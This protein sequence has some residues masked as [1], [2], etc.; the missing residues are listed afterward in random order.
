MDVLHEGHPGGTR[1]NALAQSFVWW[2]GINNNRVSIVKECNQFQLTS[3]SLPHTSSISPMEFP[4]CSMEADF[5]G[6]FSSQMYLIVV[7]AYS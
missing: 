6:P 7:Y 5:A 3:R 1:V 2:P 4:R